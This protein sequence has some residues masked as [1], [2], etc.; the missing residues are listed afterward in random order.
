MD[1]EIIDGTLTKYIGSGGDVVI[2]EGVH[3]IGQNC[4]R[5]CCG[6]TS[7]TIG[8]NVHTIELEAFYNCKHLRS[9]SL[10]DSIATLGHSAFFNC[11]ALQSVHLSNSLRAI[12]KYT[13]A[14]CENL[15]SITIPEGVQTIGFMAFDN[16][17][18]L[19][20]IKLPD[21]VASVKG[22]AFS[23]CKKLQS[24]TL[25][26]HLGIIREATFAWCS[27]LSSVILPENLA[28]IESAAF[29][30]CSALTSLS[31]PKNVKRIDELAFGGCRKLATVT[32]ECESPIIHHQAFEGI[33]ALTVIAPKLPWET[34]KAA[35]LLL[36]AT[37]GFLQY[38]EAYANTPQASYLR[39]MVS[40]RN[41]L[42][43]FLLKQDLVQGIAQYCIAKKVTAAN[44]DDEFIQ[45][46]IR[47]GAAN[48][49]A[50]LM[51]WKNKNI[52]PEELQR[53]LLRELNKDPYNV[54]DMRKLWSYQ[55]LPDG[56]LSITGYKGTEK[57]IRI[58]ERIGKVPV[59]AL[60]DSAL[61]PMKASRPAQQ[62]RNLVKITSITVPSG[63]RS[64][65]NNAFFGCRNLI[66]VELPDTLV[67]LGDSAFESCESLKTIVLPHGLTALGGCTFRNCC[68]LQEVDIPESVT[69][70]RRSCFDRCTSFRIFAP[71][72][73]YAE[74]FAKENGITFIAQ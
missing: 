68:F 29:L 7:V 1:F 40:H 72:G 36:Q 65:G 59:T 11:R 38:P 71:A 6:L 45:P 50:Y 13:F 28:L 46:A 63:I 53:Q 44:I 48:C 12:E 30:G 17:Q 33:N 69:S 52:S 49:V 27:C 22:S 2:P 42:I 56:T 35:K 62:C 23:W 5:D 54:T 26:P 58:P 4:F 16:C 39:Y 64:I 51:D 18:N 25:P 15:R 31:I 10:P 43:P 67:F 70:I 32:F 66:S 24:L 74:I 73:S 8:N 14:Y 20:A 61:S 55:K 60:A 9:V 21:S 47:T 41:T 37:R 19:E 34:L 3:T 57:E